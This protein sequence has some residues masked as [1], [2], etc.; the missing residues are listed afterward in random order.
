MEAMTQ[1]FM[2]HRRPHAEIWS[3]REGSDDDTSEIHHRNQ[4]N[5][6][7][8]QPSQP[9]TN[10]RSTSE[11]KKSD[12]SQPRST[13][14]TKIWWIPN[15]NQTTNHGINRV[16][17]RKQNLMDLNQNTP[18]SQ[19]AH[20]RKEIWWTKHMTHTTQVFF[21]GSDYTSYKAIGGK[22]QIL[23]AR[24]LRRQK[25]RRRNWQTIKNDNRIN[26][27][28]SWYKIGYNFYNKSSLQRTNYP[29]ARHNDSAKVKHA[30]TTSRSRK[31]KLNHAPWWVNL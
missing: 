11:T 6:D 17:F 2:L 21:P 18:M 12:G 31:T 19:L 3:A 29:S 30:Y 9:R 15:P 20:F 10:K 26:R 14:E 7:G 28:R 4:K 13:S 27:N 24:I 16:H 25:S 23:T 8:S 22:T 1:E 5:Y